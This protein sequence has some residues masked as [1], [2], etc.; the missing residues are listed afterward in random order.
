MLGFLRLSLSLANCRF[1]RKC[2]LSGLLA[3]MPK[4]AILSTFSSMSSPPLRGFWARAASV[5]SPEGKVIAGYYT[6]S[7]FSVEPGTIPQQMAKTLPQY[8]MMPATLIGRLAVGAAFR[9]QGPGAIL[10]YVAPRA[11]AWAKESSKAPGNRGCTNM[12]PS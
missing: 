12:P 4:C 7:Q 6:L 8:P 1:A 5:L 11:G 2:P 10:L 3:A 9:G